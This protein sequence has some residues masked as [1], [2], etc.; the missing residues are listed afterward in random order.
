MAGGG[1]SAAGGPGSSNGCSAGGGV[2]TKA[3]VHRARRE[4][5]RDLRRRRR[6]RVQQDE[7]CGRLQRRG[8]PLGQHAGVVTA[9]IG[10]Y[11]ELMTEVAD[12]RREVHD[13]SMT[14]L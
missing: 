5:T 11:R 7:P 3:E 12:I 4:V 8:E 6:Q 2:T 9:R 1:I 10:G 13:V 14:S